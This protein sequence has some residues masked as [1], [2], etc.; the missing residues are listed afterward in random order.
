MTEFESIIPALR[1]QLEC[2]RR[3]EKLAMVQHECVQQGQTEELLE[4]LTARQEV[5]DQIAALQQSLEP[6][7]QR[8]QQFLEQIEPP[9]RGEAEEMMAESRRL[10]ESIMAADRNDVLVLQQRKLNLGRQINEAR[11][12]RQVNRS[13]GLAAYGAA[14]ARVDLTR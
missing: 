14:S 9:Q 7:R 6:A 11:A 10:L 12:A 5:L 2:Y 3:L 1:H 13:Y 8:W 4:L